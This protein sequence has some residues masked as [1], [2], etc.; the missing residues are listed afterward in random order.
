MVSVEFRQWKDNEA[1]F[2]IRKENGEMLQLV[3]AKPS[4]GI[5]TTAKFYWHPASSKEQ[6][7]R[8]SL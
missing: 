3:F 1:G 7:R 6:L 4:T 2:L 5:E 8:T